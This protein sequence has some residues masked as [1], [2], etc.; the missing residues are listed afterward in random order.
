[1]K[2]P[3]F[4]P[5]LV[6]L[7]FLI[8]GG[9][10]ARAFWPFDEKK[11]DPQPTLRATIRVSNEPLERADVAVTSFAPVIRNV[12]P[13]VVSI[14]S[15]KATTEKPFPYYNEPAFKRFFGPDEGNAK[16]PEQKSQELGSGLVVSAD[17]YIITNYH[18]IEHA[19]EISVAFARGEQGVSAKVVGVDP[20]TDIAV[21]RI[22]RKGL[23]AVTFGDSDKIEVGDIVL[24]IGNPFGLSQSVTMGI[25]SGLSRDDVG[26]V[27]EGYENFIQTDASINPGNSGGALSDAKGRVIGLNTAIYS[28]FGGNQG[29]GFA[30]PINFARSIMEQIIK[31]GRV[32]RGYLGISIQPLSKELAEAFGI[33]EA[34]GALIGEV[35]PGSPAEK[36]GLKEGDVIVKLNGEKVGEPHKLRL[37]ISQ[38]TPNS[39]VGLTI[40]RDGHEKTFSPVLEELKDDAKVELADASKSSSSSLL[41]GIEITDIDQ[42][43]RQQFRISEKIEGALI[44]DVS[45]DSTAFD[46]G[47]RPGD[48]IMEIDRQTVRNA[49]DAMEISKKIKGERVVL[50]IWRD[51]ARYIVL[52][53]KKKTSFRL[54]REIPAVYKPLRA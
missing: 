17:G 48:I 36:V 42:R 52:P 47:I 33:P 31:N 25:I 22:D 11:D 4:I 28:Q 16:P 24:A 21:L 51:G 37:A 45:S 43:T 10:S 1:M 54:Q 7:L 14:L 3:L 13:A 6:F 40:I 12:A 29:I 19:R 49:A 18:V 23:A 30:V 32:V 15:T 34:E 44:K 46:V 9:G 27:D 39:P 38:M 2:K 35:S 26:V 41:D 50:R 5:V 53:L 20:K 8:L